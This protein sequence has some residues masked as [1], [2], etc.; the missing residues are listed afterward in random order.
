MDGYIGVSVSPLE[1]VRALPR[2]TPVPGSHH[3]SGNV[4]TSGSKE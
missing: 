3:E 4:G 1:P 2:W